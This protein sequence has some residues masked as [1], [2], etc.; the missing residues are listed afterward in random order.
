M[1]NNKNRP[2]SPGAWE[3][4]RERLELRESKA[5]FGPYDLI[6]PELVDPIGYINEKS[7]KEGEL[8]YWTRIWPASIVLATFMMTRAKKGWDGPVLE[9]GAGLA[10]PGLVAAASGAKVVLTDLDEDA[11]DFAQA[12][13]ELS[14]LE[15]QVEV[16]PLDW[17][18]PPDDMGT[19]DTIIGSEVLYCSPMYPN[20]VELIDTLLGPEGMTF[21]AH[22]ERPFRISFFELAADRFDV[23]S[24]SSATKAPRDERPKKVHLHALSRPLVQSPD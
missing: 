11:L 17:T 23:R 10:I 6:L 20:L 15:D 18:A 4:L 13:V 2:G 24:T 5:A 12:A 22:E 14:D 3:R 9:L 8:P 21:I 16:R 19:F 1:S 7:A